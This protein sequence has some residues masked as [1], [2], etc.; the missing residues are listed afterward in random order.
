MVCKGSV[1]MIEATPPEPE[2]EEAAEG[3]AAHWVA[4]QMLCDMPIPREGDLA[5]NGVAITVEMLEGAAL[6]ADHIKAVRGATWRD[7]LHV[8]Q[9]AAAAGLHPDLWGT[10]DSWG[11]D[12]N[13]LDL[14]D[15]KF[16]HR[17]VEVFE[18]WQLIAYVAAILEHLDGLAD[19]LILVRMHIVQP[20]CFYRGQPVRTWEIRASDL[21]SYFNTMSSVAHDIGPDSQCVVNEECIDCPASHRCDALQRAGYE[22]LAITGDSVPFDLAPGPLAREFQKLSRARK[23]LEA[24]HAGLEAQVMARIKAG[25]DVPMFQLEAATTRQRWTKPVREVLDLG[26]LFG[27]DL[28]KPALVT[29]K[30][31]V[32][33]GIDEA[34]IMKYSDTPRGELRVVPA[35]TKAARKLFGNSK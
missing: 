12:V 2:S 9:R 8:E 33:F 4:A 14:F 6:Y 23:A 31:A 15:Y 13:I 7:G 34:V 20:R 21:R 3:T 19:Q 25:V 27:V 17:Y 11:F 22:A 5:P 30:Q 1:A 16:G 18:C 29:P 26:A 10:P 24:R 35:D 32:G 28:A